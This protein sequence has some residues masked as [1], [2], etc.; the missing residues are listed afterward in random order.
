MFSGLP[1][2]I[3]ATSVCL[4]KSDW[5]QRTGQ[6]EHHVL[7]LSL[8]PLYCAMPETRIATV[9][10]AERDVTIDVGVQYT[11]DY[12]MNGEIS[13]AA[14]DVERSTPFARGGELLVAQAFPRHCSAPNT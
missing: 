7:G 6:G 8:H 14:G 4:R 2:D 10:F 13:E 12:L 3:A 11:R 1:A 5:R 9:E